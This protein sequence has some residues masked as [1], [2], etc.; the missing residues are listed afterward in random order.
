MFK[1]LA[2]VVIAALSAVM[3][4]AATRPDTFV[5][6]RSTRVAAAPEQVFALINDLQRFN[7]WNP[8]NK[9][10]PQVKGR[11]VGPASGPGAAYEFEG[12]KDVGR[13]RI[14]IADA[15][16]ASAVTMKLDMLEP[17][18]AHN[19]VQFTL[20]PAEGGTEVT[21]AMQGPLPYVAKIVHLFFNM[22][23]M[24]GHDFE[25]GLADLKTLAE[26]R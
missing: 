18:E 1:I 3:I 21:W 12:N 10:D 7:S 14:E 19:T 2:L 26:R 22:D 6:Q 16:P 23:R 8:F 25:A 5:V 15:K 9:K 17:F 13:G 24:V 20:T 11:Y 4:A